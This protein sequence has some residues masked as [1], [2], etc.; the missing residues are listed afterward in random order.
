MDKT[1]ANVVAVI[2]L[3]CVLA[4]YGCDSARVNACPPTDPMDR[5]ADASDRLSVDIYLDSTLSM[6]GFLVRGESSYYQEFLPMLERAAINTWGNGLISFYSFGSKIEPIQGRGHLAAV[7]KEFYA[8]PHYF[9]KTYIEKVIDRANAENLTVIVT[10]LFQN[11]ADVTLLNQKLRDKYISRSL[12]IGVLGIKSEFAGTVYDVGRGNH[13]FSYISGEAEPDQRRPFYT[14]ILGQHANINRYYDALK[15]A[16][17]DSFPV[18]NFV[19]L[20]RYLVNPV[21]SFDNGRLVSAN[22]IV[23]VG[24]LLSPDARRRDKSAKQFVL[25]G[26]SGKASFIAVLKH[27]GLEHTV[28]FNA[29]DLDVRTSVWKSQPDGLVESEAASRAIKI[30]S[31]TLFENEVRIEVEIAA[32]SLPGNGIYCLK[33]VVHP[34]QFTMP[35]WVTEW[36]MPSRLIERWARNPAEFNGATTFNLK[37]FLDDLL[38]T[39]IQ[40]NRP[41]LAEFNCYIKRG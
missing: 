4:T 18:W 11:D 27:L 39:T 23:E 35:S 25:R 10:D 6:Q 40:L 26:S 36:D 7:K 34:K 3:C 38:Q 12:A 29:A 41:K 2:M 8:N 30:N 37:P 31:A 9:E 15:S 24:G 20:S 17:L 33:T 19:I 13:S 22:R 16:G 21:S 14:L 28:S 1:G 32:A 5:M